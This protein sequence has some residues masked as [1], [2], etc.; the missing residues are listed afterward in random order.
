MKLIN[1]NYKPNYYQICGLFRIAIVL[2]AIIDLFSLIYD[3]NLFFSEKAILPIQ[4]GLI[5]SEYFSMLIPIYSLLENNSIEITYFFYIIISVYIIVLLMCIAGF[6]TRISFLLAILLQILI[7][8][9]IPSFNYGYDQFITMSFYYCLIF[10]VGK[11]YSIDS[12]NK[13]YIPKVPN[14]FFSLA[15]FLKVHLCIVYFTSGLAKCTDP[16]WWNGNAI[17]RAMADLSTEFYISPYILMAISIGTLII[18]LLYP[19]FAFIKFKF[20]RRTLVISIILMHLGI[21]VF[22]GLSSF[23]TVMII[24]NITAFYK[25]FSHE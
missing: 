23:A 3:F 4:L 11:A 21:G 22:L 16:N 7:F 13:N 5:D 12:I 17:W 6:C 20:L 18:E 14:F 25:D 10:P 19:I 1:L 15:T 24:W 9:S 8:R 2:L